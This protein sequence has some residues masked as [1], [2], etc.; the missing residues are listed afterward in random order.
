MLINTE[1]SIAELVNEFV[2]EEKDYLN[3]LNCILIK[4]KNDQN[5]YFNL[6]KA[7]EVFVNN[8]NDNL[9]KNS[10]KLISLVVERVKNLQ[11][12]IEELKRLLDFA[13]G[14][15]KDVV[16]APFAVKIVFCK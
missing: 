6:L 7:I 10:V 5:E 9:K 3:E 11:L 4:V 14:K 13:Y 2:I 16:C 8:T 12:P 15:M 1:S